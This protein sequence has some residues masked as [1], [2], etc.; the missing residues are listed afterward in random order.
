MPGHELYLD[1]IYHNLDSVYSTR[2]G[3]QWGTI[4]IIEGITETF[5]VHTELISHF[6]SISPQSASVEKRKGIIPV[7][8]S[9]LFAWVDSDLDPCL[10]EETKSPHS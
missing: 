2:S 8:T 9:L 10:I 7:Q 4:P 1:I 5:D 6:F 3:S